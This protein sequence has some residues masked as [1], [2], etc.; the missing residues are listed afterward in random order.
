MRKIV[1]DAISWAKKILKEKPCTCMA[2]E[3]IESM[4]DVFE[5]ASTTDVNE[6]N[7]AL[8]FVETEIK[9]QEELFLLSSFTAKQIEEVK[10]KLKSN[11]EA[12]MKLFLIHDICLQKIKEGK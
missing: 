6:Y 12:F 1:Q 3:A 8:R 10:Q 4:V 11:N 2:C 7:K 9:N 5:C